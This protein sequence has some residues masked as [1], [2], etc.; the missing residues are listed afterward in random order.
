VAIAGVLGGDAQPGQGRPCLK[1]AER[2]LGEVRHV[3]L[4]ISGQNLL[5]AGVPAGP[6]IGARLRAALAL[7]LRGEIGAGPEAE[8]TAA[9]E[10]D[11]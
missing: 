7:R 1:A 4:Q 3:R 5:D 6:E 11:L 9:L 10:V 8:L 2:W